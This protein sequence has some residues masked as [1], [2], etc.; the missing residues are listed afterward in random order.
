MGEELKEAIEK[1]RKLELDG[2]DF[3]TAAAEKCTVISGKRL[4]ESFAGDE[5]RHLR[6]IG[7]MAEG[8][9]VDLDQSPMPRDAIRT[10]F[11]AAKET[12][13]DDVQATADEKDA[14][15]VA[16]EMETKSYQLYKEAAAEATDDGP[17]E[18]FERL[19]REENQ[20]YEMLANTLEYL[21][22]NQQWF[23]WNEWALVVGDQSSLGAE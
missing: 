8:L 12:P 6:M 15:R 10:L 1:A 19:A 11:S 16:M 17:R 3:Y 23:M 20:H 9:G 2:A 4:F 5:R 21:S 22:S 14:I 18:L 13:G 7:D